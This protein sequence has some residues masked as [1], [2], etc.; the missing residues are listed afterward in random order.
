MVLVG[1][2]QYQGMS[3]MEKKNVLGSSFQIW[4]APIASNIS[5]DRLIY[6][7]LGKSNLINHVIGSYVVPL[8]GGLEVKS[9]LYTGT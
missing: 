5:P 4:Q 9:T 6:T 2:L 3:R 8:R 1:S 7:P